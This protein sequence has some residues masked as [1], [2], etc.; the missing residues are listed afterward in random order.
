MPPQQQI[1]VLDIRANLMT[2]GQAQ[3][4]YLA[5]HGTYGTLEQLSQDGPPAIPTQ[6]RGYVFNA[7][8]DGAR[9]FKVTATPTDPNKPGWPTLVI[10]ETMTLRESLVGSH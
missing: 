7:A 5:A 4:M 2:I 1:D 3:R 9:S 10:D 8:V 6:N